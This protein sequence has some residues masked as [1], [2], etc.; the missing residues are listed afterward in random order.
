MF[1]IL[2]YLFENYI[3]N[4]S[5][6]YVNQ[7]DLTRELVKAGFHDDDILKPCVGWKICPNCRKAMSNLT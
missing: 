7:A 3:H 2:V 6:I 5:E 1:D 4:E